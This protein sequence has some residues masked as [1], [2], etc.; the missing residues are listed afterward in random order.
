MA[1]SSLP[2]L[3]LRGAGGLAPAHEAQRSRVSAGTASRASHASTRRL[4]SDRRPTLRPATRP[5][6]AAETGASQTAHQ[7]RAHRLTLNTL[8][9]GRPPRRSSRR[10]GRLM[11]PAARW[12]ACRASG[13]CGWPSM[14]R[15][16]DRTADLPRRWRRS[17]RRLNLVCANKG[18]DHALAFGVELAAPVAAAALST[19]SEALLVAQSTSPAVYRSAFRAGSTPAGPKSPAGVPRSHCPVPA[20]GPRG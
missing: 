6:Q 18:L 10:G 1:R 3:T 19:A 11:P 20:T 4:H 12:C 16:S 5:R 14:S 2:P 8:P 9:R 7:T 17:I 13:R 15:H